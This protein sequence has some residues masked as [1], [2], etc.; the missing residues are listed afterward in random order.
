M[1]KVLNSTILSVAIVLCVVQ[2]V[3]AGLQFSTCLSE[4]ITDSSEDWGL[5][6]S[7]PLGSRLS[8]YGVL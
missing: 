1:D 2:D 6:E 5:N 7:L 4:A 8:A 3:F